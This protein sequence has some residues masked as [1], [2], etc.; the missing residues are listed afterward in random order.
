MKRV[1]AIIVTLCV[2]MSL[3]VVAIANG[4]ETVKAARIEN[5]GTTSSNL[6]TNVLD[7]GQNEVSV[8]GFS[9]ELTTEGTLQ[10]TG[11]VNECPFNV[12]ASPY[13][14]PANENVHIFDGTDIYENYQVLYVAVEKEIYD[15]LKY[16]NDMD[17]SA[18]TYLIKLYMRTIGTTDIVVVEVFTNS[19]SFYNLMNPVTPAG[20][21]LTETDSEPD[22][23]N[24]NQFWYTTIFQPIETYDPG[25]S[26]LSV[27][28]AANAGTYTYSYDHM[29]AQVNHELVLWRYV[30]WP[31]YIYNNGDFRTSFEIASARTWVPGYPNES[32][33][34]T[35]IYIEDVKIDIAVDEGDAISAFMLDGD[36][37]K[38][39]GVS[40]NLSYNEV[41]LW[42]PLS[43]AVTYKSNDNEYD[44][45]TPYETVNNDEVN[46]D[47][48]RQWC[49]E[50]ESGCLLKH[51]D[52]YFT[53][54]WEITNYSGAKTNQAFKVRFTYEMI[55]SLDYAHTF[56]NG[57]KYYTTT[58][59]YDTGS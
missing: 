34:R 15:S 24:I 13:E 3:S 31:N 58:V 38:S 9:Y 59:R 50:L 17:D 8:E 10:F 35:C 32:A 43:L 55:N 47:F 25:I 22:E 51:P 19:D 53:V 28:T 49:A 42:G 56:T 18:Y 5:V 29:G 1:V 23:G 14:K 2:F 37:T 21:S 16:F 26:P 54:D 40:V 48:K 6:K 12:V 30:S 33:D 41:S 57:V 46:D 20:Y 39:G 11:I 36:V 45:N 4:P 44:L 27:D 7:N 52:Q